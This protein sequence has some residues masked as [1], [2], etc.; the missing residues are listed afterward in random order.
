M[1]PQRFINDLNNDAD[2]VSVIGRHVKLQQKGRS[3]VGLCPFHNEKTPSFNVVQDKGFYHCFGCGASGTALGFLMRHVHNNDFVAAVHDLAAHLGREVPQDDNAKPVPKKLI[4]QMAEF[5]RRQLWEVSKVREYLKGRGISKKNAIRFKLGYA[6]KN[7]GFAAAFKKEDQ[8]RLQ[9]GLVSVGLAKKSDKGTEAYPY[10]RDRLMIPITSNTGATI[11]FGGRTMS[12]GEP[13]YLNSP[14]SDLFDKGR[15]VFALREAAEGIRDKGHVIVVEG[16]M[17]VLALFEHGLDNAV[18]TMGTAATTRQVETIIN[19]TDKVC[20][21]FDGDEAGRRASFKALRNLMPALKDGKSVRFALLPAGEDPD[22]YINAKGIEAFK[23]LVENATSLEEFLL[24]LDFAAV[25]EQGEAA[26]ESILWH[27]AAELIEM[28]DREKAPFLYEVLYKKLNEASGIGIDELKVAG[29]KLRVPTADAKVKR[30]RVAFSPSQER[31]MK[32]HDF[33]YL[34]ACLY[35]K[36]DLS[37]KL[38]SIDLQKDEKTTESD[39]IQFVKLKEK[40]LLGFKNGNENANLDAILKEE[41]LIGLL[42]QLIETCHSMKVAENPEEKFA[43]VV[44]RLN[45]N[46]KRKKRKDSL[47]KKLE[48]VT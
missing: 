9:R 35:V 48:K 15:V 8:S 16:Y 23:A 46:A 39:Y 12:D 37:K 26:S 42:N 1:I 43:S 25:G 28:V 38:E 14:Q 20:F 30:E 27:K 31:K 5:Y 32:K 41:R 18:A 45:K 13:K 2:I 21:C 17:D 22:S 11:G 47:S 10:F 44:N 24:G 3:H 19:R 4:E 36:P 7:G 6:P 34:L 40:L 33:Y 29:K